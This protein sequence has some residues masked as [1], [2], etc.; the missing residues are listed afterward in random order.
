MGLAAF[1]ATIEHVRFLT[2][3]PAYDL[4]YS[5]V[6]MVPRR[7]SVT[8]RL[9]VDLRSTDGVGTTIPLVV[10]NMTAVSGRRMAETV[11][12]RGGL[13]VIPQDIPI[14]V[15]TDVVAWVKQRHQVFD[16]PIS[17]DPSQTVGEALALIPKRAHRAAVVVDSGRPVG[18][19]TVS[20][21]SDRDR[22]G[23]VR[24][25]MVRPRVVVAH[26]AAPRSVFDALDEARADLAV[27]GDFA[28]QPLPEPATAFKVDGYTVVLDGQL[29]PGQESEL[30]LS[31]SRAGQP[32]TDLQ[33]YLAAY[34]HLV[35][36][37]EGDLAY[38]HVHPQDGDAGPEVPFAVEVPSPGGYRLFFDFKHDGVVRTAELAVRSHGDTSGEEQSHDH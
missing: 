1:W 19:V 10:S 18:I 32:V 24:D 9:D 20:G 7:S 4:T 15:V 25:A 28:P 38:L 33:P 11:A 30:T 23:Q 8:S 16:T 12:R 17:L 2:T 5:D 21:L 26:D 34:G 29:V 14:P 35:A 37:R 36:L 31:V 27:A 22:F 3:P 13:V 6:F